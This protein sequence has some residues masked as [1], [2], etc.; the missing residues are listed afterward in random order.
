MCEDPVLSPH[1]ISWELNSVTS[2]GRKG[3]TKIAGRPIPS[4]GLWIRP[5]SRV[6]SVFGIWLISPLT[7]IFPFSLCVF[8]LFYHPLSSRLCGR[9]GKVTCSPLG[10]QLCAE[11]LQVQRIMCCFGKGADGGEQWTWEGA[12]I[13]GGIDGKLIFQRRRRSFTIISFC[14]NSEHF[15]EFRLHLQP[16]LFKTGIR[17]YALYFIF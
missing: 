17:A 11:L 10:S 7:A 3:W 15:R 2:L 13:F 4:R 1:P 14:T 5:N 16:D 12:Q 8:L 9:G 6:Q